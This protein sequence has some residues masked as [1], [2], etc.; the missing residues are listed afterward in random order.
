MSRAAVVNRRR[1]SPRRCLG[2]PSCAG[3]SWDSGT[4]TAAGALPTG[5][6]GSEAPEAVRAN[7][8]CTYVAGSR[9]RNP[10][11]LWKG[12]MGRKRKRMRTE[13]S[14]Q[15]SGIFHNFTDPSTAEK[16]PG[17]DSGSRLA[18]RGYFN[19]LR[20][21]AS[22]GSRG[23]AT[24]CP[25]WDP[26]SYSVQ[27]HPGISRTHVCVHG[28][29]QYT[30][31]PEDPLEP[32]SYFS[33]LVEMEQLSSLRGRVHQSETEFGPLPPSQA[34]NFIVQFPPCLKSARV[35]SRQAAQILGPGND[36]TC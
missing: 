30:R 4:Q 28:S 21:L 13:L 3:P 35:D 27:M 8:R 10:S 9:S 26:L 22:G 5:R 34:N 32:P 20:R 29:A 31:P 24:K 11:V 23:C 25:R 36:R 19:R 15:L 1:S 18:A 33:V 6:R 2:A 12:R 7:A 14:R 17:S 16:Q